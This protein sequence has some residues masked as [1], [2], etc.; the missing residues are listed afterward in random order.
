MN[1]KHAGFSNLGDCCRQLRVL[2]QSL[3]TSAQGI[4]WRFLTQGDHGALINKNTCFL[5]SQTKNVKA[6]AKRQTVSHN[7]FASSVSI[8]ICLWL[9]GWPD[10]FLDHL[11]CQQ[12][13]GKKL[14][15]L[16]KPKKKYKA[17]IYMSF[18]R[19]PVLFTARKPSRSLAARM[20]LGYRNFKSLCI[21]MQT[22]PTWNACHR[23]NFMWRMPLQQDW[24]TVRTVN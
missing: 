14:L 16:E 8:S 17:F 3:L 20:H 21:S 15:T 2:L 6:I 12:P 18:E 19:R 23:N 13:V 9:I 7:V 4:G 11:E 1:G 24:N 5:D 22:R 10:S